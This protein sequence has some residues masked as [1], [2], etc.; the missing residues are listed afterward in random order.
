MTDNLAN[1]ERNWPLVD[2][3]LHVW[4]GNMDLDTGAVI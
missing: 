2:F 3:G 4:A 1:L